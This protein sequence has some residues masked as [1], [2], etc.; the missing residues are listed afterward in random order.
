[1]N[2]LIFD[3]IEMSKKQFY[4]SKKAAKLSEVDVNKIVVSNKIKRNN[5]AKKIFIGCMDNIS[6]SVEP[7]CLF[8]PQ[9]SG[10]INTFE[11]G[12]KKYEF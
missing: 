11:N 8:L 3:D 5:E 12:G 10:W 2:K 7:L 9:M 1:M 6:G 4:E